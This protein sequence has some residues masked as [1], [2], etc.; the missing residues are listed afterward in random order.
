[1]HTIE[2][3]I[4]FYRQQCVSIFKPAAMQISAMTN[5]FYI[6]HSYCEDFGCPFVPI[7]VTPG[8]DTVCVPVS[9]SFS[10]QPFQYTSYVLP[11]KGDNCSTILTVL[12]DR[13]SS[14]SS[15]S[16]TGS[17]VLVSPDDEE[18]AK[19]R[20]T[21]YN[22]TVAVQIPRKYAPKEVIRF[23]SSKQVYQVGEDGLLHGIPNFKTFL[24]LGLDFDDVHVVYDEQQALA[25][26]GDMLPEK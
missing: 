5:E 25:P 3:Q 24:A 22:V 7:P 21:L 20:E 15:G 16:S 1:M 23:S 9:F 26:I 14:S 10:P 18:V 8:G 12:P 19:E 11:Y 6:K 2:E 13:S 4:A 17:L